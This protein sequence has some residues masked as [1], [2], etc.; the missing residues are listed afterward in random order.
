MKAFVFSLIMTIFVLIDSSIVSGQGTSISQKNSAAILS[1]NNTME[2]LAELLPGTYKNTQQHQAQPTDFYH[3]SMHIDRIWIDRD[4]AKWFYMKQA[5]VGL[6]D[7]PYQE[8]IYKIYR[9]ERDTLI[10]SIYTLAPSQLAT[11][12]P[13]DASFWKE[14]QPQDLLLRQG[15]AIHL[16]RRKSGYFVGKTHSNTCSCICSLENAVAMQSQISIS[17]EALKIWDKGFDATGQ[18]VWGPDKGAYY[19][20]RYQE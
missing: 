9:G 3:V 13:K 15:C 5:Q 17:L 16:T 10:I 4:D 20:E 2:Q 19:F 7:Y 6:L 12:L 14:Q 8:H 11:D 18:K 1:I